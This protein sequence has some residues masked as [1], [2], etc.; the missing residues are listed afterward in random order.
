MAGYIVS[1]NPAVPSASEI[2]KTIHTT[3][4]LEHGW[5]ASMMITAD[6]KEA[7]TNQR[8]LSLL[9]FD[10]NNNLSK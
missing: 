3:R 6:R 9:P 5:Y 10:L 7:A 4:S 8:T 1:D 2:A